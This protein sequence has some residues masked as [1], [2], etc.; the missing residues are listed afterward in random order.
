MD[1]NK[2]ISIDFEYIGLFLK[3]RIIWI[4]L[5]AVIAFPAGAA[6][7]YYGFEITDNFRATATVYSFTEGGSDQTM[8]GITAL[9]TY[10]ETIKSK[11]S[12]E[13]RTSFLDIQI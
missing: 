10:S 9:Q 12:Q 5:A 13:E 4:I 11:K 7:A 2:V 3:H 8:L 6:T 1:F